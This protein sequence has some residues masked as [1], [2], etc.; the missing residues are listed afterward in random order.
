VPDP[1]GR[2]SY[3]KAAALERSHVMLSEQRDFPVGLP[4]KIEQI[5]AIPGIRLALSASNLV[6]RKLVRMLAEDTG[7]K[8]IEMPVRLTIPA[9]KPEKFFMCANF[10]TSEREIENTIFIRVSET[11]LE[12]K[13]EKSA[14]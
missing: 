8:Y 9:L 3:V 1:V 6:A 5:T 14:K 12:R 11:V 10:E 7:E 13:S 2:D 4:T